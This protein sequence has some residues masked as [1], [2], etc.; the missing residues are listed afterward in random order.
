MIPA[1]QSNIDVGDQA[2]VLPASADPAGSLT[3]PLGVFQAAITELKPSALH[4]GGMSNSLLEE[5]FPK[6]VDGLNQLEQILKEQFDSGTEW[7]KEHER[8]LLERLFLM[9]SQSHSVHSFQDLE[10]AICVPL[11]TIPLPTAS[12]YHLDPQDRSAYCIEDE[13]TIIQQPRPR[14]PNNPALHDIVN[15]HTL[16]GTPRVTPEASPIKP[17]FKAS[18]ST[19]QMGLVPE[20]HDEPG[21]IVR[22]SEDSM[23][24]TPSEAKSST[25]KAP[26]SLRHYG[27][28]LT[29]IILVK[30]TGEVTYVERDIWWQDR[31]GTV[32][33]GGTDDRIYELRL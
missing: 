16:L 9:M 11:C 17:N 1:D 3:S 24:A 28:R 10:L 6:V 20:H 31:A 8:Q 27:T 23:T 18:P 5:P 12:L 21:L 25:Q 26:P 30:W 15:P 19:D 29:T 13:N 4:M 7:D 33:N 32:H 14:K 2:R 22:T